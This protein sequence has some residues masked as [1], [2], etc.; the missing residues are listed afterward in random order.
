MFSQQ[1]RL[2]VWLDLGALAAA[3]FKQKTSVY[4]DIKGDNKR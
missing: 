2:L 4:Q 3:A 1:L